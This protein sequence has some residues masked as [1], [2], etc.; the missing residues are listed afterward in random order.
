[1][2]SSVEIPAEVSTLHEVEQRLAVIDG[3]IQEG[4]FITV[5]VEEGYLTAKETLSSQAEAM[6][7]SETIQKFYSE[8]GF[9]ALRGIEELA[10]LEGILP[11]D[12]ILPMKQEFLS[13]LERAKQF[14]D[15]YAASSED[16]KLFISRVAA[17]GEAVRQSTT[18]VLSV[19]AD[20]SVTD[21]PFRVPS[22]TEADAPTSVESTDESVQQNEEV[23]DE[24]E[25][26]VLEE[27][28]KITVGLRVR[29]G[30]LLIGKQGRIVPFS[31]RHYERQADYSE[32]RLAALKLLVA[33]QSEELSPNELWQAMYGD[34][35][36]EA[37]A[38]GNI[39]SWLLGL[40][41]KRRPLVIFNKKRGPS[42]RYRISPEF[43]L[44]LV[45]ETVIA[46]AEELQPL[47]DK[48]D[49]YIAAAHL[50][51]FNPI[52]EKN[53]ISPVDK[54][55]E[56]ALSKFA[57]NYSHIRGD[58]QAIRD[59]RQ[60]A[61]ERILEFMSDQDRF[62]QYLE[63]AR[64]N[65]ADLRFVQQ[66]FDMEEEQK[67]MVSRLMRANLIYEP[68][69]GNDFRLEALD[70]KNRLIDYFDSRE[71]RNGDVTAD[72]QVQDTG[73]SKAAAR[74]LK[75]KVE[76]VEES[77]DKKSQQA[78]RTEGD[79]ERKKRQLSDGEKE[80]LNELRL[81]AEGIAAVY[82]EH[83]DPEKSYSRPQ[84]QATF[85]TLTTRM[86]SNASENARG[87]RGVHKKFSV[88]DVIGILLYSNPDFQ[89]LC[90][91]KK[92]KKLVDQIIV[93]AI[94]KAKEAKSLQV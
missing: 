15:R 25:G 26:T 56:D 63:S 93:Q 21:E 39:R 10:P 27:L 29:D 91:N 62:F 14:F 69:P 13:R 49:L 4:D 74:N 20:G 81:V 67:I 48:G 32:A 88:R 94:D 44:S 3:R 82:M 51:K 8:L 28:Q 75:S 78:E 19:E 90:T 73:D 47:V 16:A 6:A 72:V 38:M 30:Q 79:A 76:T 89:N 57:P 52:L 66:L 85:S 37:Q 36:F 70:E 53:G 71:K 31:K 83:Y 58:A 5:E 46:P 59:S 34:S 87:P 54:Q 55:I 68:I 45:E 24:Q 60:A 23:I 64:D 77:A 12:K 80:K 2:D 33:R 84:L 7:T 11:E 61:I 40:S 65:S 9:Q 50:A 22:P 42:A 86:V 35:P 92:F 17:A 41:Y 1:M 43:N 18:V